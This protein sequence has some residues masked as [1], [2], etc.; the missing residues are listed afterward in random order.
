MILIAH[1][2]KIRLDVKRSVERKKAKKAS[3]CNTEYDLENL[4]A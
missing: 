2:V 1:Q 4:T 3:V